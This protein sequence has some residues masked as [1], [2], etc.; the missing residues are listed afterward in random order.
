MLALWNKTLMW[1][2]KKK[3]QIITNKGK[4]TKSHQLCKGIFTAE[5][6]SKNVKQP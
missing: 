1:K 4:T 5:I 6:P 2:A 3:K